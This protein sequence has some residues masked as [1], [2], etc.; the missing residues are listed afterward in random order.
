MIYL[1]ISILILFV[2]Y[3]ALSKLA[4]KIF[5][6]DNK[7][8]TP[9]VRINDGI[10]FM[11][12]PKWK[13]ILIELLNIAGLGPIFGA[14]T[15]ALFGP[16]AFL[17]IV[18]GSLLIGGFHDYF[19]GMISLRHDGKTSAEISGIYLGKTML[20]I[21]RVFTLVV[22]ILL[23]VVFIKGP[24]GLLN[25]LFNPAAGDFLWSTNFWI[26]VIFIYVVIATFFPIDQIIGR[27]YPVFGILFIFMAIGLLVMLFGFGKASVLPAFTLE[28]LHYDTKLSIWPFLFISIACGAISGFHGTQA[29]LMARC[30]PRET[31]EGR[32][33][34]YG[35]MIIEALIALAWAAAAMSFFG[36]MGGFTEFMKANNNNAAEVVNIIATTWFGKIGGIMAIL[37]VVVAPITST[38]SSFRVARLAIADIFKLDQKPMLNR[39]YIIVPMFAIAF[40]LLQVDFA[41]IWRYFA[42]SNQ[43]LGMITLWASAMYVAGTKMKSYHF[44]LSLP[45]AFMTAIVVS[46]ILCAPEGLRLPIMPS[47]IAGLTCALVAFGVFMFKIAKK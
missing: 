22:L 1:L 10:D 44:I 42:F 11:V 3:H 2:G 38:D 12:M 39:L 14:I 41:I 23:G 21:N 20:W 6:A 43:T 27:I 35:A 33:I 47:T 18:F 29:P 32:Q 9:A 15:G 34:F 45:A 36:G 31:P 17:W 40:V 8:I 26:T 28:N 7:I 24:A 46:Y 30:L 37:G 13:M 4:D 16:V 19:A 25:S 5:M